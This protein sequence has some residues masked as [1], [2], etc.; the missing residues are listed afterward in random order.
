MEERAVKFKPEVSN[1]VFDKERRTDGC[2]ENIRSTTLVNEHKIANHCS[3]FQ[4]IHRFKKRKLHEHHIQRSKCRLLMCQ[5]IVDAFWSVYEQEAFNRL[6]ELIRD[7][8]LSVENEQIDRCLTPFC[9]WIKTKSSSY[10]VKNVFLFPQVEQH[11]IVPF[12]DR[13]IQSQFKEEKK[14]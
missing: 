11:Q 8:Y 5:D 9:P 12:H 10:G 1:T 14:R 2:I 4:S 13:W 6:N 3:Q 7:Y